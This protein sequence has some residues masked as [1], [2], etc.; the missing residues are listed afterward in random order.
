[1]EASLSNCGKLWIFPVQDPE[2]RVKD[3]DDRT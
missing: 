2:S 1:M 3:S